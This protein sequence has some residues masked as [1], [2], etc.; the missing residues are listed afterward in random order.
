MPP[1]APPRAELKLL[2]ASTRTLQCALQFKGNST[3]ARSVADDEGLCPRV[4]SVA[5]G[6]DEGKTEHTC[7][8]ADRG[9][10]EAEATPTP[11]LLREITVSEHEREIARRRREQRGEEGKKERAHQNGARAREKRRLSARLRE[12]SA[13]AGRQRRRTRS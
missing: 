3:A 11:S 7:S 6:R 9:E 5:G 1:R 12:E 10:D 2:K 4:R 8:V 13:E